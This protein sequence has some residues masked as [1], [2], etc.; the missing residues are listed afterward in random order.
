MGTWS[1]TVWVE[2]QAK[3]LGFD[4]C[5]VVSAD[6][7]PELEHTE[8]WLARGFAGEMK[9][10]SD[11]RRRTADGAFP[12]IRSVVVCALNYNTSLPKSTD[13]PHLPGDNEPHGWISRYAWGDDYHEVLKSRLDELLDRKSTRLNSSHT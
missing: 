5:G 10:L 11:P 1:D 3:E 6:K 2:S 9:Y 7:F 13:V 12:G 4:L 8:E